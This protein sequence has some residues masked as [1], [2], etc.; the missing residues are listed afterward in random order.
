MNFTNVSF[1]GGDRNVETS[2][3]E[4]E[5][6]GKNN[7]LL[8]RSLRLSPTEVS[9][10]LIEDLNVNILT[11]KE[12][13]IT[14]E[15]DDKT[16]YSIYSLMAIRNVYNNT[17][18]NSDKVEDLLSERHKRLISC[19]LEDLIEYGLKPN[20]HPA[21]CGGK[22]KV[23]GHNVNKVP[24]FF[25][26]LLLVEGISPFLRIACLPAIR[27]SDE[28]ILC[29]MATLY[30]LLFG[31]DLKQFEMEESTLARTKDRL[32]QLWCDVPK[33][34]YFRNIMMLCGMVANERKP[35]IHREMLMKLWSPGGFVALLFAMQKSETGEGRSTAEIVVKLVSQ[36]SYP[37]RA[38]ESLAKQILRFL[39]GSVENKDAIPY[40]G[41]GLLSLKKLCENS[42]FNRDLVKDWLREQLK[43]LLD[44]KK[45]CITVMEWSEFSSTV[46]LLFQVFCTSTIECLPSDL[47]V[48]YIPILITCYQFI[49]KHRNKSNADVVCGHLSYLLLRI[50]NN[51]TTD[52]LQLIIKN[53]ILGEYPRQWYTLDPRITFEEDLLNSQQLKI[54]QRDE[55]DEERECYTLMSSNPM[56]ALANLLKRSSFSTLVYK[57]FIILF[58][59]FPNIDCNTKPPTIDSANN[60]DLL[61]SE[62][63]VQ[64]RVMWEI[65]SRYNGKIQVINALHVLIEH[66][67]L[68]SLLVENINELLSAVQDFLSMYTAVSDENNHQLDKT[69]IVILLTLI[70]EIV[71]NAP[72][73]LESLRHDLIDNLLK[74][75]SK[76]QDNDLKLQ[77]LYL[78][79]QIVGG[80]DVAQGNSLNKSRFEEARLLV[81]SKEPYKQ[82]E[83]IQQF[84]S[85]IKA[86]DV[87]TISNVHVV[88][89]L[90]LNTLTS[91]ESYTFLNCVRLFASLVY[92]NEHMIL[93]ILTEEYLNESAGM[94]YRLVIGETLLKVCHE[95]G[96]LCYKYKNTL[97]NCYMFGCRSPLDEFRFSSFS[98][99]A[100]L[101]KILSYDVQKYFQELLDLI[102]CELTTGKYMPAKRA[103][104]MVLSELL[105]GMNNLIDF[106]EMLLPIYRLLKLL[107]S[108][109]CAD[110]KMRLHAS[111]GLETLAVKCKELFL[112]PN[113]VPL[114]KKIQIRGINSQLKPNIKSHILYMD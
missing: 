48:P 83:G 17:N 62:A 19:C 31:S 95:I 20:I 28:I 65:S 81:E 113:Q 93:D 25:L 77:I 74:L 16:L 73:K 50:L 82:V 40:M 84:I 55:E 108:S 32:N 75:Q 53:V 106:Q 88:T 57:I 90:A 34:T 98:N 1:I 2:K 3:S 49:D 101:C 99:L 47:L 51:R 54:V 56:N 7:E 87:F 91:T 18:F 38:Q 22:N 27:S 72:V 89:A 78:K 100:Q 10:R 59:L 110:E 43:P 12:S 14:C 71:E 23:F 68:K 46:H 67:P 64:S 41:P 86:K 36:P 21:F 11:G 112:A 37:R 33:V 66:K 76:T 104:V 9:K 94:D 69:V 63:D 114:E 105:S 24:N 4:E 13:G 8:Q 103:A 39:K 70:R 109:E 5:R 42:N 29:Y 85:L 61:I 30:T 26:A 44:L 97:L 92:L 6:I 107:A 60:V 102:N 80:C 35:T 111:V 52:E 79:E 45:D 15:E 96:P 58:R